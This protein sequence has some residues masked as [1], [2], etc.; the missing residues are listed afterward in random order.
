LPAVKAALWATVLDF[1]H[2]RMPSIPRAAW[3]LRLAQGRVLAESG[4]ALR[5]DAPYVGGSRVYYYRDVPDEAPIPF[6]ERVL[7]QDEHLVV[8]DKP[9]FLP[10]TPGGRFIKQTLLVRLQQRLDLPLLAPLHRIDRETA[11]LVLFAVNPGERGAYHALFSERT[12]E[13]TYEAIA[14]HRPALVFPLTRRSRIEED[15]EHFFRMVETE[16]EPNSE[17]RIEQTEVRGAWARYLLFPTT[18][19]RHQLRVHMNAIGAPI[20]GDQLYPLVLR[21]PADA[22]D[23]VAPLQLLARGMA[24]PDPVTGT[25]RHFESQQTLGWLDA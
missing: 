13:K 4:E 23:F 19:K 21:G 3:A 2:H 17:T 20:R 22:E 25:Q 8:A 9:H 24:F 12:M 5:P 1:L 7:F 14:P 15:P 10:V 11:G 6:Q 18:G 16:G